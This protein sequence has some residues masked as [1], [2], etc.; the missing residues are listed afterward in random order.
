MSPIISCI[1]KVYVYL[2]MCERSI[3]FLFLSSPFKPFPSR[4]GELWSKAPRRI[5]KVIW[6]AVNLTSNR[7]YHNSANFLLKEIMDKR[8]A[9]HNSKGQLASFKF[10]LDSRKHLEEGGKYDKFSS[11]GKLDELMKCIQL[12]STHKAKSQVEHFSIYPQFY[13]HLKITTNYLS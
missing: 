2:Y 5:D 4:W 6:L 9:C 12:Q 13:V 8:A 3:I 10:S 7:S 11:V 1:C